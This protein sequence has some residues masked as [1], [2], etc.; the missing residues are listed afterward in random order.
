[1]YA[2]DEIRASGADTEYRTG[3]TIQLYLLMVT[4]EAELGTALGRPVVDAVYLSAVAGTEGV[5][6]RR[7]GDGKQAIAWE[8]LG[9]FRAAATGGGGHQVVTILFPTQ[10]YASDTDDEKEHEK[11]YAR[12]AV[13]TAR[14]A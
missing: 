9:Q 6:K 7:L 1:M 8:P 11:G 12:P 2:L 13:N 14:T 10:E 4:V 3:S 5:D